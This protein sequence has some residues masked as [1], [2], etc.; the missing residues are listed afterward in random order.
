MCTRDLDPV[1]YAGD[2]ISLW[3][4]IFAS[5]R[6]KKGIK[7]DHEID[8]H[9]YTRDMPKKRRDARIAF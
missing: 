2:N 3:V 9:A 6:I 8:I 5:S 1:I 7:W 4:K